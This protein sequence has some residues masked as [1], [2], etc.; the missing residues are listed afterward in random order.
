MLLHTRQGIV[1]L[2]VV[3]AAVAACGREEPEAPPAHATTQTSQPLR[4][5]TLVTGCLRAG[6]AANTFVLTTSDTVDDRRPANYQ[7][8]GHPDINLADHVGSRVEVRGIVRQQTHVATRTLEQPAG[9]RPAGEQPAGTAG[10]PEVQT[11]TTLTIRQLD[12]TA[13]KAVGGECQM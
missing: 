4:V 6:E 1:A 5:P 8:V 12:V 3:S 10:T 11:G 7:L 13:L 9:E 2:F